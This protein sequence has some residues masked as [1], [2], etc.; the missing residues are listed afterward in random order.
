MFPKPDLADIDNNLLVE[1]TMTDATAE[2][3]AV[4]ILSKTAIVIKSRRTSDGKEFDPSSEKLSLP[5]Q[6]FFESLRKT[7]P[8]EKTELDIYVNGSPV[9]VTRLGT[10]PIGVALFG[11]T[12]SS[13]MMK[14]TTSNPEAFIGLLPAKTQFFL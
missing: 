4:T 3:V 9:K 10:G 8:I 5:D 14:S 6:Q 13:S 7:G 1:L 11:T 2:V 12:G